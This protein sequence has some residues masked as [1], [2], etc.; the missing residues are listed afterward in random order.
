MAGPETYCLDNMNIRIDQVA[1]RVSQKYPFTHRVQVDGD[2]IASDRV[3]TWLKECNIEYVQ[4]G[5]GVYYLGPA[6]TELLLL[7]W[8]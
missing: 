4:T 8:S 7:R 2:A 5:W 1:P 3:S 6:D